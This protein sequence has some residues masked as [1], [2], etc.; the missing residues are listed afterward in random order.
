MLSV[1]MKRGGESERGREEGR[2][3]KRERESVCVCVCVCVCTSHACDYTS[4]NAGPPPRGN[5]PSTPR[6]T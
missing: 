1:C 3:R 5:S 4:G 2:V 6:C